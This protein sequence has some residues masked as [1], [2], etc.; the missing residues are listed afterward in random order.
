MTEPFRR[1]EALTTL[2]ARL[3]LP[4]ATYLEACTHCGLCAEACH[5]YRA[6]PA[7]KHIPCFKA[8]KVRKVY[9]R[10]FTPTGKALPWLFG[11]PELT[12]EVLDEWVEPVFQCTM[13]RRCSIECPL[14]IDSAALVAAARNIL[15]AAGKAPPTLAEHG[16]NARATGSPLGLTREDFLDRIEWIEEELQDELD[17]DEFKIPLDLE[18]AQLLFIPASLELMKYPGVIQACARIFRAA[19]V[20]WTLSSNRFDITNYGVFLGDP[21]LAKALAMHEIEEARRLGVATVVTSECGHAYRALRWEAPDWF[22][23][24]LPF[25][26][27]SIVELADEWLTAGLLE[28]DPAADGKPVTYHDPCNISRNGGVI[29]EPRRVLNACV[30]DFREMTP[31]RERN[32]CCGGGGGMLSMPEYDDERLASGGM[33]ARQI[34]DSGAQVVATACANCHLQ[35]SE[36][37]QHYDLGVECV[38]VTEIVADALVD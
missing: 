16:E 21:T 35:L 29:D 13:C 22:R 15:T 12:D 7:A 26:V 37:S 24:P 17:D 32:W 6:N 19:G 14:G 8:D 2:E 25:D 27:K 38:S 18:G 36:L 33:K 23:E 9:Q 31:N 3:N 11:L 1:E 34:A 5:L 28:L 4:M 30:G 10:Y 20:S